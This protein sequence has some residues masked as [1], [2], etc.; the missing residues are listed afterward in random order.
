MGSLKHCPA[1]VVHMASTVFDLV[2]CYL[3]PI[4]CHARK[5]QR[6]EKWQTSPALM[7]MH[8]PSRYQHESNQVL[9]SVPEAG[10]IYISQITPNWYYSLKSLGLLTLSRAR[11][12]PSC[13]REER[14]RTEYLH[15]ALSQRGKFLHPSSSTFK[16]Q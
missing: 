13:I 15:T 16:V 6:E 4:W 9:E 7:Q 10:P 1:H 12:L 2:F 3:L 8:I 11:V 5:L 14:G